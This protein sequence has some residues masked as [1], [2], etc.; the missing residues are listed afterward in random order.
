[1][2]EYELL[3]LMQ[4]ARSVGIAV[5]DAQVPIP[6]AESHPWM[7]VGTSVYRLLP[8]LYLSQLAVEEGAHERFVLGR[9][10]ER[11]LLV[12]SVDSQLEAC[13]IDSDS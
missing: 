8:G 6:R 2:A 12:L 7:W 3:H 10:R 13:R 5:Q 9:V 4:A 1:M 11:R